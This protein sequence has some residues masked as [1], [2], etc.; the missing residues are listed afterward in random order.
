MALFECGF[1]AG[2]PD[3]Q[4]KSNQ[5]FNATLVP[6]RST[7]TTLSVPFQGGWAFA[8]AANA[9]GDLYS[10]GV[11]HMTVRGK[12]STPVEIEE[13][14]DP[15]VP[16]LVT[17]NATA[18]GVGFDFAVVI[19]PGGVLGLG[20]PFG[21]TEADKP[22]SLAPISVPQRV[23][24][25]AGGERHALLLGE[26]GAVWML[27]KH[28]TFSAAGNPPNSLIKYTGALTFGEPCK[29]VDGNC[30]AVAAGARHSLVVQADGGLLAWGC[31][32]HGQA[33]SGAE[34]GEVAAP[35]LV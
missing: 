27:G 14:S 12:K 35:K 3:D 31:N 28:E 32:V 16:H 4:G 34:G 25:A 10:W 24:C 33:G 19:T 2:G 8:L 30:T 20:P 13:G 22:L 7:S 18:V 26:S 15:N 21:S 17:K 9:D 5:I 11:N 6:V 23:R 29:V 1:L